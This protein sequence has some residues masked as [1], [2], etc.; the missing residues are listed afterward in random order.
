MPA[1]ASQGAAFQRILDRVPGAYGAY[2]AVVAA[3]TRPGLEWRASGLNQLWLSQPEPDGL[4]VRPRDL[5]PADLEAGRRI[6][7]G[8]VT[9][10]GETLTMGPKGDPWDRPSPSRRFAA[11]LHGFGWIRH[12]TA[13]GEPGAWEALRLALAW[14]RLFGGWNR[15][16]WDGPI[17]ERRVFNLAC[18]LSAMSGPASDAEADQLAAVLARQARYL[19]A[20]DDGPARAAERTVVAAVAGC[21]LGG[22]AGEALLDK[23]LRRLPRRLAAAVEPEGTHASR[24]PQ[25]AL[26]LLFDLATL[27]NTLTQLGVAPPAELSRAM[28]RLAG[29]VRFFTL[30]DGRL[31]A[32]QGG[33]ALSGAYVAAARAEDAP[34]ERDAPLSRGGFH[35][36][37]S[38]ALQ[39]MAD[40]G[41]PA[42]GP[43][44]VT[45]CGQPLALEI[46]GTG[47]RLV[48]GSAWSPDAAGPQA[49]RLADA[50]SAACVGEADCGAP[51]Q[52]FPARIL[53][54]RLRGA[55][56]MVEADRRLAEGAQW[57]A[58]SHDG[59][60]RRF[61]LVHERKLYLDEL[62]DELRGEDALLPQKARGGAEGRR[63]IPFV[64]RFHLAPQVSALV[65]RD[66][67]SVLIKA[68]GE[69]SGWWLR[70]D[71][72]DI[73]LEA[74]VTHEDGQLRHTQQ[75]VLRGQARLD[76]GA[77]VRWK[78][79]P[80]HDR[81]E[82]RTVDAAEGAA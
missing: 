12:L 58:A 61:G 56:R 4:G 74:S 3:W 68:E 21:A 26:E 6:L 67:K 51:L 79:S 23:A 27:E 66:R 62:A 63:F 45:A 82:V 65:A 22:A 31:A 8:A 49:L 42:D 69:D 71:A 34:I 64:V 1:S 30:R 73:S 80:A 55:Y 24:S 41:A 19:L 32:F 78:L 20:L 28:D 9:L 37:E 57:L 15:F 11:A 14:R 46:L 25:A 36:L 76:A 60:V 52:G 40:A 44:R 17:L 50:A 72:P 53:G 70:T 77:K 35:R 13:H 2:A 5:R 59:W 16:A 54:P 81:I 10:G 43:W 33:E 38:A 7:A 47:K 29:A 75:I 39:V 48:T 18:G